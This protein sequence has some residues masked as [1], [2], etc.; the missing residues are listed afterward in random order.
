MSAFEQQIQDNANAIASMLANAKEIKDHPPLSVALSVLD[1][2][3]VQLDAT[4]QTVF[5]TIQ[6]IISATGTFNLEGYLESGTRAGSDLVVTLGDYD[7]S[8]NSTSFLID[9]ANSKS[10]LSN[11]FVLSDYGVGTYTGSV[12]FILA[13]TSTGDVIETTAGAGDMILNTIQ[14][15]TATKTFEDTTFLLRNVADTFDGSFLNTN[16]ADRIYTLQDADGTLAFLSDVTGDPDQSFANTSDA[17]SHTV[18]L[19]GS[20]GSFKLVEGSNITLTTTGDADDGIIT[21]AS[22]GGGSFTNFDTGGDSGADQTVDDGDLLDIIGGVGIDTTVSKASTTVTLSIALDV[23]ELGVATMVTGDWIVF[24]NAGVSNKALIS[25]IPLSIFNDD[26]GHTENVSTTLSI[27]TVTATT[28]GITSDGSADDIVLLEADTDDAGLLGAVKWDE[29]VAST[30]HLGNATI[31]FLVDVVPWEILDEGNGDGFVERARTT[32]MYGNIGLRALDYS[33]SYAD[34]TV[35]CVAVN[36]GDTVT[37]N[38]LV[39][40]AVNGAKADNTEFQRNSGGDNGTARDLAL[41]IQNDSRTG[42][43]ES[44]VDQS[45]YDNEANIVTIVAS[46]NGTIGTNVDLASS[47]GS[48]LAVSGAFLSGSTIFGATGQQATLLTAENSVASGYG[49]FGQGYLLNLTNSYSIGFGYDT[50][51][52]G[53]TGFGTGSFINSRANY[54]FVGG[55][56]S[57]ADDI[58]GFAYGIAL[59]GDDSPGVTILGQAN[60]DFTGTSDPYNDA[61]PILVVGAGTFTS[62]NIFRWLP[63]VPKTVLRLNKRGDLNLPEYGGGSITGG[64]A[65]FDLQVDATG[66]IIEVAISG[67]SSPLTTKG[68]I[69]TFTTVDA[70]LPISGNDGWVLSED[71]GEATGLKWIALGG[72]GDML[73]DTTQTVTANKTFEDTH[74]LLRNVADTFSASF[75]NTITA[76][77]IYTLQ[78]AAGTLAFVTRSIVNI[79]GTK[80]QFN[81]AVTD[82]TIMYIGDAP[83][84]HTLLSHTI[85]GETIGHVLVA[86]S[87]TT[88]SIRELLGSEISN[89]EG[90]TNNTGNVTKVSTPVDNQVGV[91]TG[92]GTLEGNVNFTWDGNVLYLGQ[93]DNV[94][95]QLYL[96]GN[97]VAAGGGS[98]RIYNDA[99]NDTTVDHYRL[100]AGG[101]S[102]N[103]V[104]SAAGVP[105]LTVDDSTLGVTLDNT[106]NAD[107]DTLGAQAIVTK[108][109]GDANYSGGGSVATDVIWDAIGD[110]AVGSG[111]DTAIRLARGTSL[112]VLRVNV[113]GTDLEYATIAVGGDV[114]KVGTP[115]NNEVAV[116]T[117]DGTLEGENQWLWDG[118]D[119]TIYEAV[120]DGNPSIALGSSVT[121]RLLITASY[122]GGTQNL[123]T[124]TFK[125]QSSLGS[126]DDGKFIFSVDNFNK[127]QIDDDGIEFLVSGDGITFADGATILADTGGIEYV[128]PTSD[129]HDFIVNVASVLTLGG[130]SVTFLQDLRSSNS[131]GGFIKQTGGSLTVPIFARISNQSS[132]IGLDTSNNTAVISNS[133]SALVASDAGTVTNV[134]IGGSVADFGGTVSG[135]GVLRLNDV[136]TIPTGVL[137]SGGL[138]YVSGLELHYLDDAGT[139]TNLLAAGSGDVTKVGTPV[140]NEVA[141]WTGDGTLEGESQWLWDGSDMTIYEAVNDG[142]PSV[143]LG[144]ASVESLLIQTNYFGGSQSLLNVSFTT[145]TASGIGDRG[146]FN[147]LVD[148]TQILRIDD[149]GIEVE[150][151][152]TLGDGVLDSIFSATG[153]TIASYA[154][155]SGTFSYSDGNYTFDG[156]D[157][158]FTGTVN[159]GDVE[160]AG[161]AM[162]ATAAELNILDLS[163]TALVAGWTYT[164]DGA[165]T[166]SWRQLL[167]SEVDDDI[168]YTK[169]IWIPDP[170]ATDDIGLWSTDEA[171]TLTKVETYIVGGTSVTFNISHN[172]NPTTIT[173]LWTAD[174][175]ANTTTTI[176]SHSGSVNDDTVAAGEAIRYMASAVSGSVTGILLTLFY[177]KD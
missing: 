130:A 146:R 13:V 93:D 79:T 131:Q 173:D 46:L 62:P 17:T 75:V 175:V 26:L 42:I 134:E 172:T 31:H 18:T 140:D 16:T 95:G 8:G 57:D 73:L 56:G 165:S 85:A 36:V 29:I 2:F 66:K 132:G 167:L 33:S 69:Y 168:T 52:T 159:M 113:G 27:G 82:G 63:D 124:V 74:F 128:V 142:N 64:A 80:V 6:D 68:D 94:L 169:S 158:D 59:R 53:Y 65:T 30:T 119:M 120:N 171:I 58:G 21:I 136:T 25:V 117:G 135:E 51:V 23:T 153:E 109:Y 43:T 37:C 28:F 176:Q 5:A 71:S 24:D 100:L 49:S 164:A 111:S 97:S 143:R 39:Y 7:D 98:L 125:T 116:W 115:V 138:L 156:A 67:S 89:T 14:T 102:G 44:T 99:N 1:K 163:A 152:I 15:V 144:S 105:I 122:G 129:S 101:A 118:S 139:D 112:Q 106:S 48:R 149:N 162:T 10:T 12:A 133:K 147:F 155:G 40:T 34:G 35:T 78:D 96:Y 55:V 54:Q 45:A 137:A 81:T 86:D 88:Y 61:D 126:S 90:W 72:G 166:A 161:V 19:S 170:T 110:L 50:D 151:D 20:G 174:K 160:I 91:W 3:A 84:S 9:D 11:E 123:A 83:T 22:T 157:H 121:N 108:A 38:G 32:S 4:D 127:L 41:S 107:I 141:V 77:R 92:D 154:D 114:T 148:E 60:V 177:T 103:L 150:G 47:N 70:R 76:N 104:L 145:F 87:A